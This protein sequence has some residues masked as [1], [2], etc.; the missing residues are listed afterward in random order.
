MLS[1]DLALPEHK[2]GTWIKREKSKERKAMMMRC[3]IVAI[4]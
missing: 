3:R 1:D 2:R 4:T